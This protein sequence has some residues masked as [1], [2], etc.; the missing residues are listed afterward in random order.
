M[1][2]ILGKVF[3]TPKGVWDINTAYTKLDLVT[4]K[5]GKNT[6]AYLASDDIVAGTQL[7]DSKWIS[8]FTVS[9][10]ANGAKGTPGDKGEP[11]KYEDFTVDQLESLKV[12]GD[13]GVP[14]VDGTNIIAISLTKNAS[15]SIIGGTATMSDNSKIAITVT[16]AEA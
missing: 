5:T 16:E 8:W 10:G 12:K 3:I 1:A 14:G 2:N 15:G 11:F 7:T 9:D 6:T 13:P 4:S